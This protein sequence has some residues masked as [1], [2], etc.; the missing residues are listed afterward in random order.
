MG[1]KSGAWLRVGT[2]PGMLVENIIQALARDILVYGLL[3][4]E[5]AGYKILMSVHDEAIAEGR[6]TD[7]QKF[8]E[9]LCIRQPWAETLPLRAEGYVSKRYKKG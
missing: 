3:C 9:Y 8:C 5:Q 4:A 1:V 6:R 7:I 2:H